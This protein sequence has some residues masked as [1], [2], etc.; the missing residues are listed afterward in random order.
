MELARRALDL[1][2]DCVEALEHVATVLVTRRRRYAEG[3]AL[4]ERAAALRPDDAGLW[5]ALG[6]CCEFAAH[7]VARRPDGTAS[8]DVRTLYERAG[9]A[10]RACLSLHP[11][12]KLADD[13]EDLLDHVENQL[14]Q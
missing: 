7:E 9:E 5:Y 1:D 11:D 10:F 2:P 14:R 8:L 4:I 13:A 3:L 12:G 6:W